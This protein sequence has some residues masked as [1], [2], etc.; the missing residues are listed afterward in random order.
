MT[1][2]KLKWGCLAAAGILF[3]LF[4]FSFRGIE[5]TKLLETEGRA[6]ETAEVK[7]VIQDNVT[8]NGN[9]IGDQLVELQILTGEFKGET[10]E[11]SS[12]SGYLFG[13]KCK[14][15]MRVVAIIN[16]SKGE[17]VAT[18]YSSNRAPALYLMI[19]IFI[20]LVVLIGGKK[21]LSSIAGLG[22]TF[23]CIVFLFLPMIYKG[24]SPILA[25][26][27]V[28]IFTT[29][30]TMCLIDGISGKSVTAMIGT[31]VG[32]IAAGIFAWM[33][34]KVADISGYNV[35][36]IE[37]LVYVEGMTDIRIGELL[38]AGILISALGAV[39]D[40][41]M[42]IASTLNELKEKNPDMSQK[43]YFLPV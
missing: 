4:F 3:L 21:G 38:F 20:G 13:A 1:K 37:N 10:V 6:F 7:K 29:I 5:K 25:A 36:D 42:S 26:V 39:M 43:H 27:L 30:V 9:D 28:V 11:A 33:F 41:G 31:V 16:E 8:E 34:G 15:G 19:G 24:V 40:V 32:V 17:I 2:N 18:V 35:S 14:E 22:F 12:S 23:L